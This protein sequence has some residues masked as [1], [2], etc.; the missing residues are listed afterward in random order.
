[1]SAIMKNQINGS[2]SPKTHAKAKLPITDSP[3][4]SLDLRFFSEN[5]EKQKIGVGHYEKSEKKQKIGVGHYEKS[6][7]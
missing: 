2:S 5:S 1:M 4:K 6:E 7:T 3:H